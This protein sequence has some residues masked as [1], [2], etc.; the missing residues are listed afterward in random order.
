M[1]RAL[2]LAILLAACGCGDD[3]T[4]PTAPSM[5]LSVPVLDLSL[6]GQPCGG[7]VCMGSCTV[8]VQIAGGLCAIPCSTAMP[9]ACASGTCN[10]AVTDG[11]ATAGVVF[12]GACGAYDGFC[13]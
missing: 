10:P 7:T 11:G 5:D 13:G 8:C 9:S 2:G 12:S 4:T 6:P 3:T 1:L